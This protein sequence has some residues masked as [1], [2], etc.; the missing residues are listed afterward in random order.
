MFINLTINERVELL[1]NM[2]INIFRNYIPNRKV[3][4]KYDEAPRINKNIKSAL[5][6]ISRL[7]RR[8]YVNGQVQSDY[9]LPQSHSKKMNGVDS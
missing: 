3:E 6:K 7:T 9:N 8:Y 5:R 4:F 2:I 1:S